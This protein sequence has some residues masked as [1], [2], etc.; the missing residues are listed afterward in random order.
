VGPADTADRVVWSFSGMLTGCVAMRATSRRENHRRHWHGWSIRR[1]PIT[2][3]DRRRYL[4]AVEATRLRNQKT[5]CACPASN[6]RALTGRRLLKR[7]GAIGNSAAIRRRHGHQHGRSH[8]TICRLGPEYDAT[9]K[10]LHVIESRSDLPSRS[11]RSPGRCDGPIQTF[12]NFAA[13]AIK[14][15]VTKRCWAR[16]AREIARAAGL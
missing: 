11:G 3:T 5:C 12:Q 8:R 9:S 15:E 6:E 7:D 1:R 16:I 14:K 10:G 13:A 4:A 2:A